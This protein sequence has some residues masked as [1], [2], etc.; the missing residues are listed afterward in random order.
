MVHY[1]SL[2]RPTSNKRCCLLIPFREKRGQV[3]LDQLRAVD[4]QRLVQ[5]LGTVS[6]NT[7]CDSDG[8]GRWREDGHAHADAGFL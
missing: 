4:R 5:K 7:A 2:S 8:E 1:R 3:A 6:A